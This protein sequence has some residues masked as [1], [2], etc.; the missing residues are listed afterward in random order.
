M[1]ARLERIFTEAIDSALIGMISVILQS[2]GYLRAAPNTPSVGLAT[3]ERC[4]RCILQTC[5]VAGRRVAALPRFHRPSPATLPRRAGP[6]WACLPCQKVPEWLGL[7]FET[8][9][10]HTDF[11][12]VW[13]HP[14]HFGI[15]ERKDEQASWRG[16]LEKKNGAVS[17]HIT[18]TVMGTFVLDKRF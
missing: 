4:I 3:R 12:F 6:A 11:G 14:D 13:A 1:W 10:A 2:S 7:I 15:M 5:K 17:Q 18:E 8:H 16:T 9:K